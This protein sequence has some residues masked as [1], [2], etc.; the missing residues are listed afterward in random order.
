LLLLPAFL[1][2]YVVVSGEKGSLGQNLGF[3]QVFILENQEYTSA[4]DFR[5][6]RYPAD[7]GISMA[8]RGWEKPKQRLFR[9]KKKHPVW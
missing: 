4:E 8:T 1:R 5:I 7:P 6:A 9:V 2:N 3:S